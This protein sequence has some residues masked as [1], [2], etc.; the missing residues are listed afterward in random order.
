MKNSERL[1]AEYEEKAQNGLA[2]V[3]FALSGSAVG[4]DY[5]DVCG[6]VLAFNAAIKEGKGTPF[7]FGDRK[8]KE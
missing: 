4:A 7:D 3:K 1:R 2:D 5:E 6:E 8:W